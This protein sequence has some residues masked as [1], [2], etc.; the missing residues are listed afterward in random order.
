VS[1]AA[2]ACRIDVWLWRA[3]FCKTRGLAARMVAQGDVRVRRGGDEM[4]LDKPSRMVRRGDCLVLVFGAR[5]LAV[6]IE[7]LGTRRGPAP[8]ARTLYGVLD[9]SALRDAGQPLI[10]SWLNAART[11]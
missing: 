2:D 10:G 5:L 4:R 7:A 9:D 1:A 6:R 3:R 8:E 11:K